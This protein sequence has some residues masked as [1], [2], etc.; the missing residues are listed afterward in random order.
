M[1]NKAT[2]SRTPDDI[3][4]ALRQA[5][6]QLKQ[7]LDGKRQVVQIRPS[8]I[9]TRPEL[10]QPRGFAT[11]NALDAEHVKKLVRRIAT[12]G[13]L[14]PPLVIQ[15]G[16]EWVCVDGHHRIAAYLQHHGKQWRGTVR[17]QWFS[18]TI[19][20]A[21]DE[22]V[23]RNDEVK[24]EMRRGD[25]YEAAWQRVV[26]GWGSKKQIREVTGVSDG[27]L[28]LMRRV[29]R[30]H[31]E[32]TLN[33]AELRAKIKSL[34][35]V[36]WSEARGIYLGLTPAEWDHQEAAAKLARALRNR[37]EDRL[38]D[39]KKVTALALAIY[40]PDL[41][42]PLANELR[43]VDTAI[44]DEDAGKLRGDVRDRRLSDVL[45]SDLLSDLGG[46]LVTQERATGQITAIKEELQRRGHGTAAANVSPSDATWA[47]WIE[48]AAADSTEGPVHIPQGNKASK[49]D[50]DI[51]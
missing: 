4:E 37:L 51:P 42:G 43:N 28:G 2:I 50:Q 10:F 16:T 12:K 33:G 19:R 25:K 27:L 9:A 40:D 30:A 21:V 3:A 46:L 22:S 39:N 48:E 13:E 6:R 17:C 24:L 32:E 7:P 14:K 23:R 47:R 49:G 15:L 29:V 45:T 36:T 11:R 31:E 26:L 41:P 5:E 18:G 44:E 20:G 1:L 8:L 34:R 35:K 38:S